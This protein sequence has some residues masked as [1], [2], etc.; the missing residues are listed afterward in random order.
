M[1]TVAIP[2]RVPR[3]RCQRPASIPRAKAALD[4]TGCHALLGAV[5]AGWATHLTSRHGSPQLFVSTTLPMNVD[6]QSDPVK[7]AS[8]RVA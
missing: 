3:V 5:S 2:A 8:I 1:C 7:S 6:R 4:A